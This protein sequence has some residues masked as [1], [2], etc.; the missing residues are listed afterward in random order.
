MN[1][2][3]SGKPPKPAKED[4]KI[5]D[6]SADKRKRDKENRVGHLGL[7]NPSQKH[8]LSEML[9]MLRK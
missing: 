1:E 4:D 5:R 7:T 3:E 2:S 9:S 6:S 8:F